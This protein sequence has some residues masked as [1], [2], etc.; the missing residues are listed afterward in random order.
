MQLIWVDHI[1]IYHPT[2]KMTPPASTG[3][4]YGPPKLGANCSIRGVPFKPRL[5]AFEAAFFG[6]QLLIKEFFEIIIYMVSGH[7][8]VRSTRIS[9]NVTKIIKILQCGARGAEERRDFY[10]HANLRQIDFHGELLPGIDVWIMRF[11]ESSFQL[12]KLIG[13][14]S[15]AI[16]TMLLF[17]PIRILQIKANQLKKI[18]RLSVNFELDL[19]DIAIL[20][21]KFKY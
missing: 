13:G 14:K 20:A 16:T 19:D 10:L 21:Q 8:F 18:P 1:E 3:S 15:C 5:V 9:S 4:S 11:F 6:L 17:G 7:D 12:V 2:P